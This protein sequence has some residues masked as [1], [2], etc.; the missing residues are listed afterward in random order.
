MLRVV[1]LRVFV[2]TGAVGCLVVHCMGVGRSSFSR[3][4]V[5]GLRCGSCGVEK[6]LGW[7]CKAEMSREYW[8]THALGVLCMILLFDVCLLLLL[9]AMIYC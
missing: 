2:G 7:K 1:V 6:A 4:N 5:A 3:C 9:A 8:W